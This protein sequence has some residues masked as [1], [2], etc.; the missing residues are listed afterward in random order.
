MGLRGMGLR[1]MRGAV[2]ATSLACAVAIL[3][4]RTEP[5]ASY[6]LSAVHVA[7]DTATSLIALL[8]AFL[9]AGGELRIT[10]AAGGGSEVEAVL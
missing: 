5:R 3:M 6:R 2:L 4:P 10:S 8:A 1:R 7:L 9:V